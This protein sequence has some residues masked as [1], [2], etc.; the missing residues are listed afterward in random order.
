[1]ELLKQM[2]RSLKTEIK[3]KQLDISRLSRKV[4]RLDEANDMRH[5]FIQT[6][7]KKTFKASKKKES[8]KNVSMVQEKEDIILPPLNKKQSQN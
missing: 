3:T 1:M 7:F 6:H 5:D 8:A 2:V 4:K